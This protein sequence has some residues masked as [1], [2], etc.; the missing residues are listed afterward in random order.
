MCFLTPSSSD[1]GV[2]FV[3][4]S[5]GYIDAGSYG[6]ADA[7][8]IWPTI[9]LKSEVQITAGIGTKEEPFKVTCETCSLEP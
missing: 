1:S 5:G 2:V 9:Y 8:D 7:F 6:V 3:S 4:D